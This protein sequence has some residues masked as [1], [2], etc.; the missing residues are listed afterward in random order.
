[1]AQTATTWKEYA[2]KLT[3][4]AAQVK[5]WRITN[6]EMRAY[7]EIAR[8]LTEGYIIATPNEMAEIYPTL[9]KKSS[10]SPDNDTEFV[11]AVEATLW[12]RK[13]R[14]FMSFCPVCKAEKLNDSII[15]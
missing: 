8:N 4:E 2:I 13:R 7:R 1:M 9:F 3:S 14:Y 11:W 12:A 5:D 6:K 10:T 15:K